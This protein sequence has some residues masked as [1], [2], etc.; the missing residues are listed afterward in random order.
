VKSIDRYSNWGYMD[1]LDGWTLVDGEVLR[2]QWPDGTVTTETI[3]VELGTMR[4]SDHGHDCT[5]PDHKAYITTT[6]HGHTQRIYIHDF[7]AER[8]HPPARGSRHWD[9]GSAGTTRD[10]GAAR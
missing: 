2:L 10:L 8:L 6:H 3:G 9:I 4:Y 7:L 5:G 1:S